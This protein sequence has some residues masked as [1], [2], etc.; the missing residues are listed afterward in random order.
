[1]IEFIHELERTMPQQHPV[2]MTAEGGGQDNR[3]LFGSPADW[4]SPGRG[5]DEEYKYDPPAAD[6]SKVIVSD[7]DHLWGH[8]GNYQWAWKSFLRGLNV[9]F[10]DP[11]C[12]V[13]GGLSTRYAKEALNRRD[14]PDWGPLRRNL[15]YTRRIA[16]RMDLVGMTPQ[17]HLASSRYCLAELGRAYLVYSP[18]DAKVAVDL[19]DSAGRLAAEWLS[20][21]TGET[22][23]LDPVDGGAQRRFVSPF[24][25]DAVL[26][27]TRVD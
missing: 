8:G 26:Y 23:L 18:Q 5:P 27:L 24:G 25:L 3:T 11:W 9:L 1:V 6:G 13:P 4:I 22:A 19:S 20:P 14:Y 12:P 21:R 17:G 15:G 16:E 10:M 2:G 7:T